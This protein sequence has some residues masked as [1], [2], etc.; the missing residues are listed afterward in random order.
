MNHSTFKHWLLALTGIEFEHVSHRERVVSAL[1]GFFGIL[2][3]LIISLQF[4][5]LGSA[6]LIVASMGASAVLIFAVPHGKLSQPWA[7]V[8]G[9]VL[10]AIV[11]VTCAK[12][13]SN[14]TLAA[15]VAVGGAIGLMHYCRCIHPPGGASALAA[16]I[17]GSAVHDLGYQYVLTP[18][19]LNVMVILSVAVLFNALLPWRLYPAGLANLLHTGENEKQKKLEKQNDIQAAD[20]HF[21]LNKMDLLV[22]VTEDDLAR[23]YQLARQHASE[24]HVP[25]NAI[26]LGHYY[27]NGAYG[28]EWSVR[29]IID[30]AQRG[31]ADNVIYRSV[32]GKHRIQT[33]VCS[34]E[35]FARWARY[36]VYLNE[37][38]WQRIDNQD[39]LKEST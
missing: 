18:V 13:I 22:D 39:P 26:M 29:R 14:T 38:N 35:E 19:F 12:Y 17:S 31:D 24:N 32:A 37:N 16:V 10:S 7:L 2:G 5:P 6:G 34:R 11:G 1:G 36:E 20:I 28:D 23:I 30:E 4:L 15:S 3:I 33:G 27:S 9:H 25:V 8:G 21:A